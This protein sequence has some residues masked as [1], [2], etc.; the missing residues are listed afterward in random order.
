M[1]TVPLSMFNTTFLVQPQVVDTRMFDLYHHI[2]YIY[3]KTPFIPLVY[4]IRAQMPLAQWS[5]M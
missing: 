1:K 3:N 2:T 4:D 5:F